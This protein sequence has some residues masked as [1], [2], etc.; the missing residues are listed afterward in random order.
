MSKPQDVVN[1]RIRIKTALVE[2]FGCKCQLCGKTYPQSVFE[3]HHL[4]P[5]EK[6]FGLACGSTTRAKSAYAEEAKK[7]TML[8]ANCHRL[9]EYEDIDTSQLKC[10]F[11]EGKYYQ[12][13]DELTTK[14][15][16]IKENQKKE[17]PYRPNAEELQ[18]ILFENEGNFTAVGRLYGVTGTSVSKWC[19][20]FGIPYHSVDYK[21]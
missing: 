3:F 17:K 6:S 11:D 21:K 14:N 5:E 10:T 18:K 20:K 4:N 8:C 16:K 15:K 12:V 9:V 13:L 7:C 1:F 2:S 19:K